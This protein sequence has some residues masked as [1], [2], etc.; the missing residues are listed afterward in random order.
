MI[1]AIIRSKVCVNKK[2]CVTKSISLYFLWKVSHTAL[3]KPIIARM[4]VDTTD[5]E[6]DEIIVML[7][8]NIE[9]TGRERI[10]QGKY[11]DKTSLLARLGVRKQAGK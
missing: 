2:A 5:A 3:E 8:K 7:L 4:R 9:T 10:A 1:Q 11:V 6:Y